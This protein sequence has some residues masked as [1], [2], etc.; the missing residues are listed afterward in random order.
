MQNAL[1]STFTQFFLRMLDLSQNLY[2]RCCEQCGVS[3]IIDVQVQGYIQPAANSRPVNRQSN[4]LDF[5]IYV[6][7]LYPVLIRIS[8]CSQAMTY[9]TLNLTR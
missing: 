7:A 8:W 5:I 1:Y 2:L 9:P 6:N 4:L 3:N